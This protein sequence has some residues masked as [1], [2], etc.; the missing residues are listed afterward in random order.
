M[1]AAG[2]MVKY[3]TD[4][5]VKKHSVVVHRRSDC[6]EIKIFIISIEL[7]V[8][9]IVTLKIINK[10]VS[11]SQHS[12]VI[13]TYLLY[14]NNTDPT[15]PNQCKQMTEMKGET[16]CIFRISLFEYPI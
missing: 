16:Q 3:N 14:N 13:L 8:I 7:Q 15:S 5:Y 4:F 6:S 2:L 11:L 1:T 10:P 9:F 12:A